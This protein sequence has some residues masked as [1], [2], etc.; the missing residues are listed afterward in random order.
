[1]DF[2]ALGLLS[3]QG[4]TG[5]CIL[6]QSWSG[7]SSRAAPWPAREVIPSNLSPAQAEGLQS[8][9]RRGEPPQREPGPCLPQKAFLHAE[10][11]CSLFL[12]NKEINDQAQS[13][14]RS[15]GKRPGSPWRGMPGTG[16]SPQAGSQPS[17]CL[18]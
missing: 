18:Q 12:T 2:A 6:Q 1:M 5:S 8:L 14:E 4:A 3:L 16:A 11:T 15:E 13:L 7:M 10:G 9:L 17:F